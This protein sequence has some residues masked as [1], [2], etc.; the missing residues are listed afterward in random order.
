ML[1]LFLIETFARKSVFLR[2]QIVIDGKYRKKAQKTKF[3]SVFDSCCCAY[4]ILGN[5]YFQ[6]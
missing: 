4:F 1:N 5:Q 2:N 3:N 6:I